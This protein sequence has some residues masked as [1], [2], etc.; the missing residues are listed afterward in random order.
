MPQPSSKDGG[1]IVRPDRY[2]N[3]QNTPEDKVKWVREVKQ[4]K[5]KDIRQIQAQKTGE[6]AAVKRVKGRTV[7]PIQQAVKFL[8]NIPNRLSI[9]LQRD[10]IQA[11]Q[12]DP[13]GDPRGSYQKLQ[14]LM[15]NIRSNVI[16][17]MNC[18]N[19][20]AYGALENNLKRIKFIHGDSEDDCSS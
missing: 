1:E 6:I 9:I 13:F 5:N 16:I 12:P 11:K 7:K 2:R 15:G 4:T 8:W 14:T 20:Y 19:I 18:R 3:R 17:Q 10:Y